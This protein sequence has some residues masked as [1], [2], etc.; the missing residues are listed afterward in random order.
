MICTDPAHPGKLPGAFWPGNR[1][2]SPGTS[3]PVQLPGR[4]QFPPGIRPAAGLSR[5]RSVHRDPA[6]FQADRDSELY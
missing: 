2:R 3:D 5:A 1:E 4:S 6:E